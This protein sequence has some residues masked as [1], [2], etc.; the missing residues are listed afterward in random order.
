M[1]LMY[2]AHMNSPKAV[3]VLLNNPEMVNATTINTARFDFPLAEN[4]T[5]YGRTPLMY[6]AEN[7]SQRTIQLLIDAGANPNLKD[8]KGKDYFD[9]MDK[10]WRFNSSKARAYLSQ[11][12]PSYDCEL[13]ASTRE[14]TICS[15]AMLSEYDRELSYLY[16]KA[17]EQ[18]PNAY[19]LKIDQRKW[20]K[21]IDQSCM[22][23]SN[24]FEC[25]SREYRERIR[26]FEFIVFG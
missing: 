7:A 10:N 19:A 3:L 18:S 12:G 8:S 15:D 26:A 21:N 1:H 22:P 24:L 16:R 17:Y 11:L 23:K 20:L 9:Y 2:A 14:K 6:A 4:L 5:T 13:A 25:L